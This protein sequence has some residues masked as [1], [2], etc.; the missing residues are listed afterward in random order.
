M[1][2]GVAD[3]GGS[4]HPSLG[5]AACTLGRAAWQMT[6]K[7]NQSAEARGSRHRSYSATKAGDQSWWRGRARSYRWLALQE[8]PALREPGLGQRTQRATVVSRVYHVILS[9][10]MECDMVT[11]GHWMTQ[12]RR[13]PRRPLMP[14]CHRAASPAA[15]VGQNKLLTRP[16]HDN[17]SASRPQ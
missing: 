4:E 14:E 10:G 15:A 7:T 3:C 6:G 16:S 11:L 2:N 9:S 17:S 13:R 12:G 8:V 1:H 5:K